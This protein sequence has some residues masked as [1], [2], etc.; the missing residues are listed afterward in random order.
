MSDNVPTLF[1]CF[2]NSDNVGDFLISVFLPCYT[3]GKNM[4]ELKKQSPKHGGNF[5][6]CFF[7]DLCLGVI[8]EGIVS[9]FWR[10]HHSSILFKVK[11]YPKEGTFITRCCNYLWCAPCALIQDK[12]VLELPNKFVMRSIDDIFFEP[13][14]E[15]E[16][17]L[18]K[19]Q[20]QI[21]HVKEMNR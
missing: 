1:H 17:L 11:G 4:E 8:A 5:W 2:E 13:P 10:A 3:F 9:P 16:I 15:V 7:A 14:E 6:N 20:L 12:K 18:K 19:D 21:P